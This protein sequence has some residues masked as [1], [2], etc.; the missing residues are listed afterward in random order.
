MAR[1]RG[2][3]QQGQAYADCERLCNCGLRFHHEPPCY[4]H[5]QGDMVIACVCPDHPES[6]PP[7]KA[8]VEDA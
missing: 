8:N 1:P 5:I 7:A 6:A 4:S 2:N 3:A